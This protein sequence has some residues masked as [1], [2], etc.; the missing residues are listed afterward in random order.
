MSRTPVAPAQAAST[1][2]FIDGAFVA[3]GSGKTFENRSPVD[4]RL[5]G[6]VSEAGAAEVDAAVNAARAAL[7]G[8]WGALD[9]SERTELLCRRG[10]F[11]ATRW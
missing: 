7:A 9:M 3:A 5:L 1:L 2:N 10:S 4:A 8:P 6:L 11:S